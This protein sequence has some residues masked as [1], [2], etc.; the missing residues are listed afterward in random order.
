MVSARCGS[1]ATP[2]LLPIGNKLSSQDSR[3]P[4]HSKGPLAVAKDKRTEGA[5]WRLIRLVLRQA[6]GLTRRGALSAYDLAAG[7]EGLGKRGCIALPSLKGGAILFV[8]D[9]IE[10]ADDAVA[11]ISVMNEWERPSNNQT[12]RD[13]QQ[14]QSHHRIFP[15]MRAAKH[16]NRQL[17]IPCAAI[18]SNSIKFK[19]NLIP[20]L[21]TRYADTCR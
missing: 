15:S 14:D 7:E 13:P 4:S 19:V 20:S 2:L 18:D 10:L 16:A 6:I 5:L 12:N 1:S 11:L 17:Q 21:A 8:Q 3:K 9:R